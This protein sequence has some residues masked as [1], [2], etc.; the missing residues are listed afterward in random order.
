MHRLQTRVTFSPTVMVCILL[1]SLIPTTP[2][3][4]ADRPA[5][6]PTTQAADGTMV[7]QLFGDLASTDPA[8]REHARDRLM[9]LHRNELADLQ[10]VLRHTSRLAPSQVIALRQ[11]VQEVYLAGEPYEPDK[12]GGAEHGFLGIVMDPGALVQH[13]L[14]QPND[15]GQAPGIIVAG[16]FSGFCA[17]RMLRDGDVIIGSLGPDKLFNSADAL[18][19]VISG[20]E[21]GT[22]V[23][24]RVLRHGQIIQ[25][26]LTLDAKPLEASSYDA[27]EVF[28]RERAEK[29]EEYWR[30]TFAPLLKE[31]VG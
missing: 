15:N 23:R 4:A 22:L 30:E 19:D 24:L 9:R 27:A 16:R 6:Q 2:S 10:Q 29:F 8:T 3:R 1:A 31:S 20:A 17:A 28:R 26:P 5:T 11:I 12:E 14:Q 18:K 21:P 25:V 13:D 7:A